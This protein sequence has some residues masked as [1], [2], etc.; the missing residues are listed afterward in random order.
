VNLLVWCGV[1][2]ALDRGTFEVDTVDDEK[3]VLLIG[4]PPVV[5]TVPAPLNPIE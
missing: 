4:A 3:D 2:G 5:P 1:L